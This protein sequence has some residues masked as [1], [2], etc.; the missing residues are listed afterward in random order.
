MWALI[1]L[2]IA[3]LIVGLIFLIKALTRGGD[4]K[5]LRAYR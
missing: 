4:D 1:A 2:A 5:N 3:G